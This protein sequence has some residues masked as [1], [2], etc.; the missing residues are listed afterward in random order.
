VFIELTVGCPL[1]EVEGV[2]L[3]ACLKA[4]YYD[5]SPST[6]IAAIAFNASGEAPALAVTLMP[7][8]VD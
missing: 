7:A 4:A 3:L 8:N 5:F 2:E 6:A 1:I